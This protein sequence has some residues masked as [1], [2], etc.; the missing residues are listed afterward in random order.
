[1][2]VVGE[3]GSGKSTL[4]F[5]LLRLIKS[6]G[7]IVFQGRELHGLSTKALRGLRSAMQF[8][9]QDPYS[10]LNPRMT[11]RDIIAEGLSVHFPKKSEGECEADIDKI[12]LEVGL[13]PEMKDRYPHEF[14]GG[15]RQRISIAR[16]MVLC[17]A[18]VVL[19]EPTSALD[20]SVQAQIIDLLKKFQSERG[21]SYIF[22]SHDLRVVRAIAQNIIV[23]KKGKIVEQ[24]PTTEIF[25][26]PR[27]EYTKT[28]I[29]AAFLME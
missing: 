15:Q 4:G 2:G 16:A 13:V 26:H 28:L 18:L 1:L 14:S 8:V 19:D 22:I 10:S 20:L 23:M 3:S 12:L 24:G 9:F 7:T 21:V 29:S 5:V 6:E 27:Q 25:A 11:I 17:P